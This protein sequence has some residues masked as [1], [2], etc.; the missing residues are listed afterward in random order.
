MKFLAE[1]SLLNQNSLVKWK[2]MNFNQIFD[3]LYAIQNRLYFGL[4]SVSFKCVGNRR[5]GRKTCARSQ[6]RGN[7]RSGQSAEN[8]LSQ[9]SAED[10]RSMPSVENMHS[11][12][13]REKTALWAKHGK[14]L[15]ARSFGIN[16]E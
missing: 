8:M 5:K 6:A 4:K 13:K 1:S 2:S 15:R 9:Q 11:R 16:P 10:M 14:F 3:C 12:A 7:T